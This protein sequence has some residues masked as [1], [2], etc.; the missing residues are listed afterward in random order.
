M[1]MLYDKKIV[2]KESLLSRDRMSKEERA[3]ADGKIYD[4]LIRLPVLKEKSIFLCY[5]NFRSE[6]DTIRLISWLFENNKR[7]FVPRVEGED[8][9]FYEIHSLSELQ[10]G[11]WGILEPIGNSD[12]RYIADEE[13]I[14]DT[15]MILPGAAFDKSGNRI[16]YGKG[17]YDRYLAKNPINDKIGICYHLQLFEKIEADE[18][19]K[20]I[21]MVV[22]EQE[23][24]LT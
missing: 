20:K 19:D 24:I 1:V 5:V 22:T 21:S 10:E 15:L 11:Y 16:G 8:M 17:Y 7:V 4:K 6:V 14:K 13:L 2:R 12:R 3:C 9:D 23:C 18:F